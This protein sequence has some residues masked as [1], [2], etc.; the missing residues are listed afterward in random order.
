MTLSH[1]IKKQSQD[2]FEELQVLYR[3]FHKHPE[4]SFQEHE[5]SEKI[6]TYMEQLG[7]S[8]QR[9]VAK[10]GVVALLKGAKDGPTVAIRADIDA[11]PIEE[12]SKL[13]YTSTSKGLMH[14][15]G[16]DIHTTCALGAAKIIASLQSKLQGTV[17]FIFQPAEE[18]NAGAKAMVEEGVLLNP[19][20]SMI[21]GLHNHPEIPVGKVALKEGPLMASVDT[22]FLKVIGEGGHGAFP[23]RDIDPIVATASIIMNL[24]TIVS[25]NVDPQQSAVIS[26]GTIHGGTAN[27]VIP[28]EVELTGTV[29]TFDPHVRESME[30]WMQRV[31]ENAA[32]SLGCSADFFYRRDLPAVFNHSEITAI[33]MKALEDLIDKEKIVSPVPSMG[34]E[35]FAIFQEKVPGCFFWL[36]VGNP[37]I[38]AVHP[39]HSPRFKAD[40]RALSIGAALLALS[41]WYGTI[42]D[43]MKGE[44]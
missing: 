27:N 26:F 17:K 8:V 31:I 33:G 34:G 10:T 12:K 25:R 5:T 36:G 35:D 24:Q 9:N 16:H 30:L 20:V 14:A 42:H 2:I 11:L 44:M 39:W 21:F 22:T 7:C 28:D 29:R 18:I 1:A 19:D 15:C 6:A 3:D 32:A 37:E 43:N 41:A 13:S 4:L 38:D 23:H 40:E